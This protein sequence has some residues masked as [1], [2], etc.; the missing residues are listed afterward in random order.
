MVPTVIQ[1]SRFIGGGPC[2]IVEFDLRE[3]KTKPH[4]SMAHFVQ[5]EFR[6]QHGGRHSSRYKPS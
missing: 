1:D 2:N 6:R 5:N 3:N 4:D